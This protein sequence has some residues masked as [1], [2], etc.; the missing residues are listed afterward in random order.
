[1]STRRRM[2]TC[3][4]VVFAVLALTACGGAAGNSGQPRPRGAAATQPPSQPTSFPTSRP[5]TAPAGM[6][7][8]PT[9]APAGGE[10]TEEPTEEVVPTEEATEEEPGG[11]DGEP[12]VFEASG[13]SATAIREA[14]AGARTLDAGREFQVSFTDQQLEDAVV[15]RL[16]ETDAAEFFQDMDITFTDE[17]QI[18]IAFVLT[19]GDSG[20]GVDVNIVMTVFV[21][22]NEEVMVDVESAEAGS[23]ELPEAQL[24]TLNQ[25]LADALTGQAADASEEVALTITDI[26][27]V[28]GMATVSGYVTP[29]S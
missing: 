26:T 9:R 21:D 25:A 14:Y 20:I 28:A 23:A 15:A 12:A 18:E 11:S 22:E 4:M 2:L 16:E 29:E 19:L 7:G 13:E 3:I 27:I 24:E 17:G 10:A 5:V 1:M 8:L 6:Y